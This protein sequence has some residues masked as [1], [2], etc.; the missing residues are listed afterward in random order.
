LPQWD[1]DEAD[2]SEESRKLEDV[3]TELRSRPTVM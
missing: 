1:F 3:T 2:L